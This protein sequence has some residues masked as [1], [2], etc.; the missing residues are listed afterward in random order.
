MHTGLVKNATMTEW[1]YEK[2][3]EYHLVVHPNDDVQEKI[4]KEKEWFYDLY[5]QPVATAT[6]PHIIIADFLA[7]EIMEQT[8]IRWIQKIC[9]LQKS[10]TVT[11][12]NFNSIPVHTIYLRVQ[13]PQPFKQLTNQLRIID[14]FVR[15]NDCPPVQLA[16]SPFMSIASGLP[17]D[18]YHKAVYEYARRSFH[19]SFRVNKLTLIKRKTDY[20]DYQLV[21]TFT[22][23]LRLTLFE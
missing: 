13:D 4:L 14:N 18:I 20:D 21:N 12:N 16:T 5:Q 22:L 2:Y 17:E 23:P 15:S 1:N 9:D 10:F 8:L 7:K 3:W 19:E 11:L 6:R